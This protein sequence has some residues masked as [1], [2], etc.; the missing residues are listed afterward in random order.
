[1]SAFK[2]VARYRKPEERNSW[3]Y[4]GW[5]TG[6]QVKK[7]VYTSREDFLKY[8]PDLVRRWEYFCKWDVSCHELVDDV[9]T[10]TSLPK[11]K[12]CGRCGKKTSNYAYSAGDE[13]ILECSKCA[14]AEQNKEIL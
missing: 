3:E 13:G 6:T 7:R 5:K 12:T 2:I 10:G 11:M 4:A 14:G 1:M 9:W 8:G